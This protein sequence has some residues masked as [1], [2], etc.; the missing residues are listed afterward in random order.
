MVALTMFPCFEYVTPAT[1]F[2]LDA[3]AHAY[4][5]SVKCLSNLDSRALLRMT[6]RKRRAMGNP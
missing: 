1:K 2:L 6:A 3:I 5:D 4:V